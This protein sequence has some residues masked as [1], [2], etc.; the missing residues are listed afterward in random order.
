MASLKWINENGVHYHEH[1]DSLYYNK[2]EYRATANVPALRIYYRYSSYADAVVRGTYW[3]DNDHF[4]LVRNRESVNHYYHW[5]ESLEHELQHDL[6][7]IRKGDDDKL[8]LFSNDLAL[9]RRIEDLRPEPGDVVYTR[10]ITIPQEEVRVKYFVR[11]PKHK[12]RVYMKNQILSREAKQA[13]S[14]MI[15][16]NSSTLHPSKSFYRWLN[17]K[18]G[19]WISSWLNATFFIDYDDENLTSYIMLMFGEHVTKRYALKHRLIQ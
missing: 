10:A 7:K 17:P 8:I 6:I 14:E 1:R 19:A 16:Q 5:I 3:N 11:E 13:L 15:G 18:N 2:Y 12:Y 9:L 4:V